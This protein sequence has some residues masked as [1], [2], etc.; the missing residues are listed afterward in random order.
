MLLP[1]ERGGVKVLAHD[2]LVIERE[3]GWYKVNAWCFVRRG[4]EVGLVK[5]RVRGS[6]MLNVSEGGRF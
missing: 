3:E 5:V 1:G 2:R 4:V 6:A